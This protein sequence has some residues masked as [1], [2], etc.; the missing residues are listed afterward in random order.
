MQERLIPESELKAVVTATVKQVLADLL[1]IDKQRHQRQWYKT[2]DAA[3]LL[4]LDTADNLHDLRLAGDLKKGKH[5]R[6]TSNNHAKRPTYQYHVDRCRQ[7]LENR[8]H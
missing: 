5:W 3:Q 4:D 6:Q 2:S 1:G 8:H 7:F